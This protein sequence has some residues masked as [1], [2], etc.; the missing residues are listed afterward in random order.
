MTKLSKI[1]RLSKL[2]KIDNYQL[3]LKIDRPDLSYSG[4]VIIDAISLREQPTIQL[5]SNGL[6]IEDVRLSTDYLELRSTSFNLTPSEDLIQVT[7]P[8]KSSVFTKHQNLTLEIS[9]RRKISDSLHGIY[10]CR[11]KTD[12]GQ[13]DWLLATQMESHYA[14]EVFVCLDEPNAKAKFDLTIIH[15]PDD[16][17]LSNTPMLESELIDQNW[18]KTRFAQ[19]PLM[20]TYLLAIVIGQLEYLETTAESG[21]KIRTYALPDKVK[22]TQFALNIAKKVLDIYERFFEIPYPLSKLD[23]VALPEFE[24]CAMEN[25]GLITYREVCLIYDSSST[26]VFIEQFIVEVIAHEI[27]HQWFGNLVTMDWWEDLWL[28]EGFA[29]WMA[30]YAADQIYPEWNYFEQFVG[31]ERRSAI[32]LDSLKDSHPIEVQIDHPEQ[33]K[34]AFDQI[35]YGKGASIIHMLVHFIGLETFRKGIVLY[36]N[37]YS[38][39]N[40][41][42][43]QLWSALEQVSGQPIT[44]LMP[45]WT[46]QSGFPLISIEINQ[47][48]MTLKQNQFS[49]QPNS[50]DQTWSIP[51]NFSD[52]SYNQLLIGRQTEIELLSPSEL[53]PTINPNQ[54]GYYLVKSDSTYQ[55]SLKSRLQDNQLSNLDIQ[56]IILDHLILSIRGDN[57]IIDIVPILEN[58]ANSSTSFLVWSAIS[59]VISELRINFYPDRSQ[60]APLSIWVQKLI[61]LPLDQLAWQPVPEEPKNL[62]QL[63]TLLLGLALTYDYQ[64][65]KD[66]LNQLPLLTHPDLDRLSLKAK[67]KAQPVEFQAELLNIYTQ[68]SNQQKTSDYISALSSQ[69]ELNQFDQLWQFVMSDSVR[70]QD[71]RAWLTNLGSNLSLQPG[72]LD[73]MFSDYPQIV[74]KL[75]GKEPIARIFDSIARF[76]ANPKSY[77]LFKNFTDQDNPAIQRSYDQLIEMIELRLEFQ[78]RERARVLDYLNQHGHPNE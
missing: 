78:K 9:F 13:P 38:Y 5:H 6:E 36:L 27:A 23:M 31:L 34:T 45:N 51:L 77:K 19:T 22:Q 58:V 44:D 32:E 74:T 40:A 56:A 4:K 66:W 55:D 69:S 53:P 65:I 41:T 15:S 67:L 52:T 72:Y 16:T 48:T 59:E 33:I 42:T 73:K 11:Y 17:C 60:F 76:F 46:E 26:N 1:P 43:S 63:R 18:Q 3:E 50:N 70:K 10:P 47:T 37:Q 62:A 57:S 28:N 2:L 21:V 8:D 35:S 30:I 75:D 61:K 54:V 24:A 7:H 14:R 68:E 29:S 64:P 39:K 71:F 20:S 49:Y 12:Q 25:W